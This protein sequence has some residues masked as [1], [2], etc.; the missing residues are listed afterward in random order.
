MA[1]KVAAGKG[2]EPGHAEP[3]GV[4][5]RAVEEAIFLCQ[6]KAEAALDQARAGQ[7]GE[8]SRGDDPC[9]L[10]A[11]CGAAVRGDRCG[12][13]EARQACDIGR[14]AHRPAFAIRRDQA[15]QALHC[16]DVMDRLAAVSGERNA[17]LMEVYAFRPSAPFSAAWV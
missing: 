5:H 16:V 10:R 13:G 2:L 12:G 17:A 14:E 4:V 7:R 1:G 8:G 11:R 6:I 9:K 15:A 3:A